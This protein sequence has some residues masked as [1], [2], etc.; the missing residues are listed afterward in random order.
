MAKHAILR[1]DK[2]TGTA[3]GAHVES[4]KFFV[5]DVASDVDNGIAVEIGALIDGEREL[6][7]LTPA[8]AESKHWGIVSTPEL[9][10]TDGS[11]TAYLGSFYNQA[12]Q[13]VR[14]HALVKGNVISV[15]AEAID[16]QATKGAKVAL[17]GAGGKLK[18]ATDGTIG[19]ID[20]VDTSTG[21]ELFVIRID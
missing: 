10:E 16:G 11:G 3:D 5:G 2:V 14:V 21:V 15:S 18:V 19:T 20:N 1:L 6:R 17:G 8:T 12:G 7:K 13:P 4:G 9:D